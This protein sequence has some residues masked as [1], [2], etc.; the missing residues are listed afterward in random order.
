MGVIFYELAIGD[1][2]FQVPTSALSTF[3]DAVTLREAFCAATALRLAGASRTSC[4]L[5]RLVSS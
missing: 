2:R 3:C 4:S 1:S 5:R